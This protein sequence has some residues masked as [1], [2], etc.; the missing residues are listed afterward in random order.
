[1]PLVPDVVIPIASAYAVLIGVVLHA[2]RHPDVGYPPGRPVGWRP[3]L[4]LIA[5]T[6]GGGY[7]CFL[8]IVLV[9]HVV[10]SEA[11]WLLD[12]ERRSW[13]GRSS[14]PSARGRSSSALRSS[15][16]SVAEGGAPGSPDTRVDIWGPISDSGRRYLKRR[17]SFCTSMGEE[18]A[19]SLA[20]LRLH[21]GARAI[22]GGGVSLALEGIGRGGGRKI[23][24]GGTP[25]IDNHNAGTRLAV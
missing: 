15:K 2:V 25:G 24:G 4:R 5:V 9:F 8:A 3:R 12:D 18:T 14:P 22:R 21:F 7:A 17:S 23:L 6:I 13:A 10:E 1:M 20:A 19:A 16:N 11:A